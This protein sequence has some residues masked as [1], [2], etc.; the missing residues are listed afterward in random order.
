MKCARI[1]FQTALLFVVLAAF[2]QSL[3]ANSI[4]T[5]PAAPIAPATLAVNG[6]LPHRSAAAIIA[7]FETGFMGDIVP[8]VALF[9]LGRGIWMLIP[10]RHRAEWSRQ[11]AIQS[12]IMGVKSSLA[13]ARAIRRTAWQWIITPQAERESDDNDPRV[14]IPTLR[15]TPER[16]TIF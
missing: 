11:P 12:S 8:L 2:S 13:T 15:P 16:I 4:T 5:L 10:S 6:H 9:L 1:L 7:G 3:L 14:E